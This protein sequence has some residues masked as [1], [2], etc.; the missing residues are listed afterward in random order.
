MESAA[1]GP[2]PGLQFGVTQGDIAH[3]PFRTGSFDLVYST[4]VLEHFL[5]PEDRQRSMR[6]LARVTR[7][8][9]RAVVTVPNGEHVL[10]RT[11]HGHLVHED[12]VAEVAISKRE[13]EEAVRVSGLD[14]TWSGYLGVSDSF[15]QW[16]SYS[17]LRL[18]VMAVDFAIWKLLPRW[19]KR[20]LAF[21]LVCVGSK[22]RE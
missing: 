20:R 15:G 12:T 22:P 3:L 1:R 14:L 10:W 13:L 9:G 4:G 11:W 8:G 17:L 5:E 2:W 7:P 21:H 6:E 18:P 16:L 19:A